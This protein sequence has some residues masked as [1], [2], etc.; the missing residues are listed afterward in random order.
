MKNQTAQYPA[1]AFLPV[2]STQL[3]A[4]VD[5]INASGVLNRRFPKKF[6][7][8]NG[9]DPTNLGKPATQIDV[10]IGANDQYRFQNLNDARNYALECAA[11]VVNGACCYVENN[12]A[13]QGYYQ[14]VVW[15]GS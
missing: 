14:V 9:T 2:A 6:G 11:E 7:R 4:Q 15:S 3:I 1:Q 8:L 10:L 5:S 12:Q 13:S